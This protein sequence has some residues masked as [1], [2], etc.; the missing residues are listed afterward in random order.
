MYTFIIIFNQLLNSYDTYFLQCLSDHFADETHFV[1][2][3]I[4]NLFPK[5]SHNN[6]IQYLEKANAE[7]IQL[8]NAFPFNN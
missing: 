3:F 1:C 5:L 2:S 4:A 7:V 6:D 8:I